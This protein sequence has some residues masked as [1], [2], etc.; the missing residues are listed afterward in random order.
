MDR[1]SKEVVDSKSDL[2]LAFD[3]DGD[4][5]GIVDER[6]QIIWNDVLLAILSKDILDHI[7]GSKIVYNT[8]C[9]RVVRETIE[10]YG[11]TPIMCRTGH[12]YVELEMLKERAPFGGELSG[13][14]FF[15]DNFYGFDDGFYSVLRLLDYFSKQTKSVSE[16]VKDFPTYISSP[17]IKLNCDDAFK[18]IVV[19]DLASL[20]RK[21][22]PTG[23]YSY[24]DGVRMDLPDAMLVVRASDNGPYLTVRFEG[25]TQSRSDELK[26]F[27]K[28][29]LVKDGRVDLKN[30]VN[31][32]LFLPQKTY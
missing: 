16:I 28:L 2:G 19:E 30:G 20:V 6:S 21:K 32:E 24:Q 23:Q 14:F 18:N 8:L 22:Y 3:T 9:S 25:K 10:T 12:S 11:G 29:A 13:H 27:I 4:R 31:N 17:E 26:N 5:F 7:P 1:L 15:N